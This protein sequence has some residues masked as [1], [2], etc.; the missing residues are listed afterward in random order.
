VPE[1]S[2]LGWGHSYALKELETATGMFADGNVIGEGGYG[3]VYRG[4]LENG[5]QVAVKNLL[6]NRYRTSFQWMLISWTAKLAFNWHSHLTIRH[7]SLT[8]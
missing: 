1:V 5:T 7:C 4:V 8:D 6:N 3:I 2:H